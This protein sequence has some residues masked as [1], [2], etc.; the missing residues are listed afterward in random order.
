MCKIIMKYLKNVISVIVIIII[1]NTISAQNYNLIDSFKTI[2]K[3]AK[4]DTSIINGNLALA[5][6]FIHYNLDTA[7]YYSDLALKK[8]LQV[9][10]KKGI[11]HAYR[12]KGLITAFFNDYPL[13]DSLL[14]IAILRYKEINDPIGIMESYYSFA[15]IFFFIGENQQALDYYSKA[16]KIAD[17]NNFVNQKALFLSKLSMVYTNLGDYDKAIENSLKAL[18]FFDKPDSTRDFASCNLNLACTYIE[19]KEYEKAL[20]YMNT[21]LN[22]FIKLKETRGQ[23]ICFTDIATIYHQQKRYNQALQNYNKAIKL[24]KKNKDLN[25]IS[26]NYSSIGTVY[27]ELGKNNTAMKY[28]KKSLKISKQIGDKNDLAQI[29][30]KISLLETKRK[31]YLIAKNYCIK[32]IN[33][34]NKVKELDKK[35]ISIEQLAVIYKLTGKYK[36]AYDTY[37]KASCLKDSLFNIE[38]VEKIAH[39]EKKFENE[40]LEKENLKLLYENDL[41]QAE[42]SQQKKLRNIYLITFIFALIAVIIVLIQYKKKNNAYKYLVQKNIDLLNKEKEVKV[43]KEQMLSSSLSNDSKT[44]VT[45]EEKERIVKKI[46]NLFETQEIYKKHD[47]TLH[48]LA[49]R[50]STNVNYLSKIINDEYGMKYTDFLNEYRIKEVMACLSSKDNKLFSIEGIAKEA[51]FKSLSSFYCVFKKFTGVT[52]SVF[53]QAANNQGNI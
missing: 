22:I 25:G 18:K 50:L 37:T 30:Y 45:D 16:Y 10:Y 29:Y 15:T 24:D 2:I 26:D 35:R 51:G 31:K 17:E 52:P 23:S 44:F 7:L 49:K 28:F 42:I 3:N 39:I 48:K 46:E 40:K 20:N 9:D 21:A 6:E 12:L 38:K 19:L 47:L 53:R 41:K 27:F 4:Q 43:I 11:A 1:S 32:S 36:D 33:I 13:A 34:F 5:N 14:N 8:S